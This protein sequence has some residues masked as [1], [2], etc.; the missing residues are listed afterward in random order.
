MS[1]HDHFSALA[2]EYAKYRPQY[3]DTLFAYLADQV[4]THDLAWDCAT[5]NGQA[6]SR[7]AG[8]FRQVIATEPSAAQISHAPA[9]KNVEYRVE[10][11]EN[12]SLLDESV[13]LITVAQAMHWFDFDAFGKEATR[14]LKP[15][16]VLAAWCYEGIRGVQNVEAVTR[17]FYQDIIADYWPP[18][19]RWVDAGYEGI[20]MPYPA[21]PV[22]KFEL[23]AAW[24][25]EALMGYLYS[26]SAV[27]QYRE[28]TGEDP[29]ALI[30]SDLQKA[31]GE[32]EIQT[33]RWPLSLKLC[34]KE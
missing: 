25:L 24:S 15:G 30:R 6:A 27:K 19:R 10:T 11:A 2:N 22:E 7:L 20:P 8:Y 4:A 26:L 9:I 13:D 31:W 12:S 3:P 23:T 33:M 14:V 17:H 21:L 34:R 16:G 32:Q 5:G 18:E 1:F 29:V 28:Q